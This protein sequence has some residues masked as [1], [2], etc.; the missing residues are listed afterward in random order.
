MVPGLMEGWKDKA[1]S[2]GLSEIRACPDLIAARAAFISC[3]SGNCGRES[4]PEHMGRENLRAASHAGVPLP[5]S[6]WRV[7]SRPFL[8]RPPAGP[9]SSRASR[10]EIRG[11]RGF[12]VCNPATLSNRYRWCN[13]IRFPAA[14]NTRS[15]NPPLP[16]AEDQR[17]EGWRY[18][19][20]MDSKIIRE[21]RLIRSRVMVIT[22]MLEVLR[23]GNWK[24][25]A[26]QGVWNERGG[27]GS[28]T[29]GVYVAGSS[30]VFVS[31]KFLYFDV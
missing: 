1:I 10:R 24:E 30:S 7:R 17:N 11:K 3:L 14:V 20:V 8:T 28:F 18:R 9:N 6:R 26:W 15:N 22:N 25:N 27:Q 2:R 19:W 16:F 21:W 29:F 23:K 4:I 13:G 5:P 31:N 12:Y